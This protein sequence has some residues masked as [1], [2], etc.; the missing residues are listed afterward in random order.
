M[1]TV[2]R[3]SPPAPNVRA[4]VTRIYLLQADA[5]TCVGVAKT[6]F[7]RTR[8]PVTLSQ[9]AIQRG[10]SVCEQMLPSE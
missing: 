10:E 1:K 7:K 4:A 2:H 9:A 8:S 5:L 6:I 3:Q